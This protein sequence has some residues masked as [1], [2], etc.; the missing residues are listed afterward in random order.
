AL[1]AA[2]AGD[3]ATTGEW[4]I[5]VLERDERNGFG[6]YLLA[7]SRERAGDFGSSIKAYESALALLPDHGEVANDL[8]R[9]AYRMGMI[10]QAEKLFRHYLAAKPQHPEGINNLACA[11]RDQA[12]FDEA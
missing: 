1:N 6:W 10:P 5:K 11:L 9:L 8:G 4:A 7:M 2:R 3:Y 12:R